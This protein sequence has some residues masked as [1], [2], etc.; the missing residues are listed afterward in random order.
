M[1]A[2]GAD[3]INA[4]VT[5]PVLRGVLAGQSGD[6]GLPP[7]RVSAFMHAGITNHY[8]DGGYYPLGGS[9]SI[10]R[11]FVK[12]LNRAGGEIRLNSRVK[13]ILLERKKVLGVELETGEQIR[14][15]VVISNADP[16]VTFGKLIGPENLP[17]R[18]RKKYDSIQYSTSCLSLFFATDMDLRAAGLNSGN[19][20]FYEHADVDKI[21]SDG[22][23]DAMLQHETP[24]GLFLTVTTLKDP[25]KIHSGHHTCEAFAFVGYQAFENWAHTQYGARPTDYLAMKEDL[26]WRMV[27]GLEKHVPGLSKH[28]VFSSLGTPLTNEHYLNA[29]RGN[30][31]GIEKSPAQVGPWAFQPRTAFDGLFLCGASTLSHGVSGV[32]ASGIDAAKAVLNCRSDDILTRKGPGPRFLPSEDITQWPE[33]L[34]KKIERGDV[35]REEEEREF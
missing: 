11:A 19:F 5:D 24:P 3:L 35:A 34:R 12:A 21:Y 4:H 31:Y 30:L 20:W 29:T 1:R 16:G 27:R 32:T 28:I 2:T 10:P 33:D 25:S 7:S 14:A 22:L 17:S 13:R 8:L 23:T 15:G 9:F 18:L 6:H 26:A